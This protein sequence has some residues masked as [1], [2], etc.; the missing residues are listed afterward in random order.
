MEAALSESAESGSNTW[1]QRW[2][3]LRTRARSAV[4]FA[5]GML[6]ALAALL[7][8]RALLPGPPPLTQADVNDTIAQVMASATPAPTAAAS[9]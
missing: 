6:A 2:Q 8:Y 7:L 3:R 9:F 4:P 1:R 5:T